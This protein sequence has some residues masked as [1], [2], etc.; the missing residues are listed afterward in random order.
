[1]EA[2]KL[3]VLDLY[4]DSKKI[5][6]DN[7]KKLIDENYGGVTNRLAKQMGLAHIVLSRLIQPNPKRFIGDLLA[8]DIEKA[9]GK[10]YGWLDNPIHSTENDL[11]EKI[12][13]L[14]NRDR[15]IVLSLLDSLAGGQQ[16]SQ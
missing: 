9:G 2:L 15:A 13:Q 1:M 12:A 3:E 5:R 7:L 14:D 6:S 16:D 11:A 10:P 4:R 8:R